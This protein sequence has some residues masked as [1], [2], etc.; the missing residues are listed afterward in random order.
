MRYCNNLS[1]FYI[2]KDHI[3]NSVFKLLDRF[4]V[5]LFIVYIQFISSY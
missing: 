2:K 4:Q 3:L 5:K 1:L